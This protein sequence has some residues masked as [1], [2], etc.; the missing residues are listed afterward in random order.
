[1]EDRRPS[2]RVRTAAEQRFLATYE[3]SRTV[4]LS[5]VA[6]VEWPTPNPN[7]RRAFQALRLSGQLAN[8]DCD[9]RYKLRAEKLLEVVRQV[10]T[11]LSANDL[12]PARLTQCLAA[13]NDAAED[14]ET[15]IVSSR[16]A[17]RMAID[18]CPE[19][20]AFGA[21]KLAPD[22]H[23]ADVDAA[24]GEDLLAAFAPPAPPGNPGQDAAMQPA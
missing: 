1:M 19:T 3:A 16:A 8:A 10:H 13:L 23:I 11:A 20:V 22:A 12:A 14:L 6:A 24:A 2:K 4:S 15:A 5:D 18:M 9:A 7:V 17:S 21:D